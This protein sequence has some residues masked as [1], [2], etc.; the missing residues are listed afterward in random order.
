MNDGKR[1]VFV[2]LCLVLFVVVWLWFAFLRNAT[3]DE[4]AGVMGLLIFVVIGLVFV[5]QTGGRE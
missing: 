1:N 3:P 4:W 2:T 5:W